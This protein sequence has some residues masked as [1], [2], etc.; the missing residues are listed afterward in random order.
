MY[1]NIK[2]RI[3]LIIILALGFAFA[4]HKYI[5]SFNNEMDI[6]V[7]V[8]D[9]EARS[10]ISE[11]DVKITRI[12]MNDK[13]EFFPTAASSIEQ[14]VGLISRDTLQAG[15]PVLIDN[16]Y[17]VLDGIEDA[18]GE[19]GEL[20][21]A[22]F[23][24]EG[25]RIMAINL[26]STGSINNTVQKGSFIDLIFTSQEA[27][28]GGIY[29]RIIM[30]SIE[31]YD[32]ENITKTENGAVSNTQN[33]MLLVT[34][35]QSIDIALAGRNGVIDCVLNPL[36]GEVAAE[37]A[38]NIYEYIAGPPMTIRDQ[39]EYI[40]G[41]ITN[42]SIPDQSKDTLIV[43]VNQALSREIV[44]M[45]IEDSDLEIELKKT[46]LQEMGVWYE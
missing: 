40:R 20:V 5:G 41:Y 12:S 38:K 46:L 37:Y 43:G 18:T 15:I 10:T 13:E 11:S 23:I 9:I 22:Y 29:S 27:S 7:L 14:V 6:V 35:E 2:V 30:Q 3:V 21:D 28:T 16:E 39:I 8:N 32:V 36:K 45:I 33:V 4:T 31:V 25:M 44:E 26:D 24:P 34:P 17:F 42:S 19:N 1:R